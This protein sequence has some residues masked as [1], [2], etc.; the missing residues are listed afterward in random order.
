MQPAQLLG[1]AQKDRVKKMPVYARY[2]VPH[3]WP[4]VPLARML[5]AYTLEDEHWVVQGLYGDEPEARI[6][7]FSDLTLAL[8]DLW[9]ET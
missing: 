6:P 3:P 8:T 5:E 1:T 4:V 2:G 9:A 7:P